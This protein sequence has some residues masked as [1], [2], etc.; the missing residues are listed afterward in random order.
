MKKTFKLEVVLSSVFG[1]LLCDIGEV[2]KCLNFL[3]GENI[4]THQ[5]PRAGKECQAPVVEQHPFL[6]TIDLSGIN[7]SNWKSRLSEI[8]ADFPDEIEL[9][10]V[11]SYTPKNPIIEILEMRNGLNHTT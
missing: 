5:I 7:P 2:Y 11:T 1:I 10:P 9:V 3:T 4:Y 8:K 6:K